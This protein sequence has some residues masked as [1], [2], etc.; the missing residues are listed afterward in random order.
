[1]GLQWG[2]SR[3]ATAS[4][5]SCRLAG[6]W[7]GRHLVDAGCQ[8]GGGDRECVAEAS[9]DAE[10]PSYTRGHV[11]PPHTSRTGG[12]GLQNKAQQ[13]FSPGMVSISAFARHPPLRRAS[14][15]LLARQQLGRRV[16]QFEW[17]PTS[18]R[19]LGAC[20][21]IRQGGALRATGASCKCLAGLS[22]IDATS[23]SAVDRRTG[24]PFRAYP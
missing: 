16:W 10:R 22:S 19:S 2:F 8:T 13:K 20:T 1:M 11:P 4:H 6:K 24:P 7:P 17:F 23:A 5:A 21:A 18:R 3:V 15:V 14:R 9:E 12:G